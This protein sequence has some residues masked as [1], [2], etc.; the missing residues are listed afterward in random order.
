MGARTRLAVWGLSSVQ[1]SRCCWWGLLAACPAAHIA[2]VQVL[3][4]GLA[5]QGC[6]A[7]QQL[8]HNEVRGLAMTAA[9]SLPQLQ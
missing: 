8:S 4:Q 2:G 9:C 6:W 7:Q 3:L 1:H 5:R